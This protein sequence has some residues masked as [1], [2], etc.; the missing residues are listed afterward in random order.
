MTV[1][2]TGLGALSPL[3]VGMADN[4]DALLRGTVGITRITA[5][6]PLEFRVHIAGE[7]VPFDAAEVLPP[8]D[9]RRLDSYAQFGVVAGI[10]AVEDSGLD[11]A[12]VDP[13]RFS[14]VVGTGYGCTAANTEAVR[15]LDRSGPAR[16]TPA[17]AVYGAQDIVAAYLSLRWG[18]L[19]ESLCLSAACASGTIAIGQA[20]RQIEWGLADVVVVIGAD[21]AVTPRDLAVVCGSRA[22]TATHND[23]PKSACRPFDRDRDGFVLSAGAGALVL[24]SAEHAARRGASVRASLVGYGAAS[25]AHHLTAPHPEGRGAVTAM[26]RALASAGLEPGAVDH[27]NAHGT[28]TPKND[29]AEAHALRTVFGDHVGAVAVTSTKSM[30]GHMIGAAGTYEAA[31]TVLACAEGRVPPTM[32]CPDP[33]FDFL[34]VVRDEARA[35]PVTYA[36]TNSFGFGGHCATVVVGPPDA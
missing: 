19:G 26:R 12:A 6:D 4:W 32:S 27:V 13:T 35:T 33:E 17:P 31:A 29:E 18:A 23:D 15:L 1:R 22:L 34:D 10:Q 24:E 5:F 2:V 3:G 25:D 21:G 9:A 11:L 30:T 14:I 28:G 20:M 7:V 36:L 16:F 8:Q